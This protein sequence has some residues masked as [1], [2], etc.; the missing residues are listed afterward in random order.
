LLGDQVEPSDLVIRPEIA[1]G[2]PLGP[3]LPARH[4]ATATR[5]EQPLEQHWLFVGVAAGRIAGTFRLRA[6]PATARTVRLI[7]A[8]GGCRL[9][10]RRPGRRTL[11]PHGVGGLL[12]PRHR[13]GLAALVVAAVV[14]V[15]APSPPAAVAIAVVPLGKAIRLPLAALLRHALVLA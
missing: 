6:A 4:D 2:G 15:G 12:D 8:V 13:L 7:G 11:R 5:P 14:A 9:D 1:P 10:G 3:V